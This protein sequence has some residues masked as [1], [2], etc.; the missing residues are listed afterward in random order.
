MF[1]NAMGSTLRDRDADLKTALCAEIEKHVWPVVTRGEFR[2]TS[3]KFFPCNRGPT[4]TGSWPTAR[5]LERSCSR[6]GRV[7]RLARSRIFPTWRKK[8]PQPFVPYHQSQVIDETLPTTLPRLVKFY[9]QP[10]QTNSG[11]LLSFYDSRL[12][13]IAGLHAEASGRISP[14][15]APVPTV[16]GMWTP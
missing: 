4:R 8:R 15:Q 11:V 3:R 9:E 16:C 13:I 2:P 10:N 5:T 1:I 14:S 12:E 6:W 7:E